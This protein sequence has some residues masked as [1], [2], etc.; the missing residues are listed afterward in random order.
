M[1]QNQDIEDGNIAEKDQKELDF[2]ALCRYRFAGGTTFGESSSSAGSDLQGY[3][4]SQLSRGMIAPD[5]VENGLTGPTDDVEPVCRVASP[6]I[7][8]VNPAKK[9]VSF[10]TD[11]APSGKKAVSFATDA[12]PSGKKAVSFA[13]DTAPSGKKAV[14][15]ATDTAPSGKKAVSFATDTAPFGKKA[16]SFATDTTPSGE[17]RS[18]FTADASASGEMAF[19]AVYSSKVAAVTADILLDLLARSQED[20]ERCVIRTAF[21][22]TSDLAD[23]IFSGC[24]RISFEI[25]LLAPSQIYM[26]ESHG[27]TYGSVPLCD[28]MRRYEAS[29]NSTFYSN[30]PSRIERLSWMHHCIL[31]IFFLGW[32]VEPGRSYSDGPGNYASPIRLTPGGRAPPGL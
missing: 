25:S 22:S 3:E 32:H 14:S 7:G 26:G 2:G 23:Q 12:A 30:L 6:A 29:V 24:G 27:H 1:Q 19:E 8:D 21:F 10:A 20:K 31:L 9:A 18:L 4:A 28:L 5:F 13:T 16:V 15:F 11:A 17:N